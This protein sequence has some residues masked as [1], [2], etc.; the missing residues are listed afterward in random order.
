MSAGHFPGALPQAA[1]GAAAAAACVHRVVELASAPRA[2]APE[3]DD[4]AAATRTATPAGRVLLVL[5]RRTS[6]GEVRAP[7]RRY[8]M[9]IIII[10]IIIIIYGR[11]NTSTSYRICFFLFLFFLA[12]IVRIV[13][14][15]LITK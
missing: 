9:I 14:D 6:A 3:G 10:I 1:G 4:T 12:Q 15:K 7:L 13:D 5:H 2:D 8:L 11:N